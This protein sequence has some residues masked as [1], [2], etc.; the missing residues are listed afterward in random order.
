M[1]RTVH[2]IGAGLAGLASAVRLAARGVPTV[3]YEATDQEAGCRSYYDAAT[4]MRIDN[5]THILLSGNTAA[6]GFLADIGAGG[7]VTGASAARYPFVDL[8]S[9]ERSTR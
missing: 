8:A 2:I 6:L 3:V 9:K 5:G 1:P 4:E 7:R